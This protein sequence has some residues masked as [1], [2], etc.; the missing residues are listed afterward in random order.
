MAQRI[1]HK[2]DEIKDLASMADYHYAMYA[3]DEF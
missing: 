2:K 3:N 1:D